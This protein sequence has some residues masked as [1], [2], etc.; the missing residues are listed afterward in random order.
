MFKIK[1][2]WLRRTLRTITVVVLLVIVFVYFFLEG[3]VISRL[4]SKL[5]NSYG[6]SYAINFNDINYSVS[7]ASLSVELTDVKISTDTVKAKMFKS[8][9][10]DLESKSISVS[11]MSLWSI[12]ILSEINVNTIEIDAP[13]LSIA[14]NKDFEID[15]KSK[16]LDKKLNLS[17]NI[18]SFKFDEFRIKNG[19]ATFYKD[20][21]M[22]DTLFRLN[23]LDFRALEFESIQ[24][25]L[26]ELLI[27][28]KYEKLSIESKSFKLNLGEDSY[29]MYVKKFNGELVSGD[30]KLKNIHFKPP[31]EELRSGK[32]YR[33]DI[34]INE[35]DL[36]GVKHEM[37]DTIHLSADSAIIINTHIDLTKNQALSKQR[38]KILWMENLLSLK[39]ELSIKT[40]K[41]KNCSLASEIKKLDGNKNYKLKLT[42]LNGKISNINTNGKTGNLKIEL[43]SNVFNTG[44]LDMNVTFPYEDPLVS[45]FE[46][47]ISNIDLK[48]F[49]ELIVKMFSLKIEEGKLSTLSFKGKSYDNVSNGK[50]TFEYEDLKG[51]FIKGS[52]GERKQAVL[53]SKLMNMV[54]HSSN[55]RSGEN[56]PE[57]VEFSFSKEKHHGQVMLWLGGVIDGTVLTII[58]KKKH[59]FILDRME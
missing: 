36:Y 32:E 26:S 47:T 38:E 52:N 10:I 8:P 59:D 19:S 46:G 51:S 29:T 14:K 17:T 28:N 18:K 31:T 57:E 50:L 58:G 21:K 22:T 7:L 25:N 53:I 43:Q 45:N 34:K 30:L 27:I 55:P 6:K 40:L 5:N 33:G 35:L 54:I 41:F 48:S 13:H 4:E 2:R 56:K 49:N 37:D 20:V 16:S 23:E 3:F 42:N 39:E 12:F 9:V 24:E 15:E 11:N 44:E 1:K